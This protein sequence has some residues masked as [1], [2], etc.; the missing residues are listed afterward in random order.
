M[1]YHRVAIIV[2]LLASRPSLAAEIFRWTDEKG[3]IHFTDSLH[4]IPEKQR[5]NVTRIKAREAPKGAE[6]PQPVPPDKASIPIQKKGQV[7]IVQARMNEKASANFVV[8]TG[9]SYT[10]IS[11][12]TAKELEIDLEK[13][14]PTTPFQTANGVILA[15]LVSL[16]SIEVGG[17][18]VKDLTAAVHD[19]FPDPSI[20]GLL[21]LNFL[22]N[23]R[24]HIDTENGLLHLEKR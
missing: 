13:K 23:F 12:A 2:L 20:S 17:L 11:R 7:V 21:G 5:G 9:A 24:M 15:P 22:R 1:G 16:D 6:P 14:L 10:M 4:N 18:Q 3:V 19:V 8:D